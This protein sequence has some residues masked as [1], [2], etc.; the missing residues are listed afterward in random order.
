MLTNQANLKIELES[1]WL[2]RVQVGE[3]MKKISI[4]FILRANMWTRLAVL[5]QL[6]RHL[7]A[8]MATLFDDVG[9]V[10]MSS[11]SWFSVYRY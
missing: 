9:F 10:S 8:L 6:V 2:T 3:K 1:Y 7:Q 4:M 5:W 11:S